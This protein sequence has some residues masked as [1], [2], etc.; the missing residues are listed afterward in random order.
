MAI[1]QLYGCLR[2]HWQ[3]H[4][5]TLA[6]SDTSISKIKSAIPCFASRANL[7]WYPQCVHAI[8][9]RA[10]LLYITLYPQFVLTI[11]CR[12]NLVY[13]A[14]YPQCVRTNPRL[15]DVVLH[16]CL[17]KMISLLAGVYS[18]ENMYFS[19]NICVAIYKLYG[20][21]RTHWQF[22]FHTLA[23]SDTSI[24]KLKSAIPRLSSQAHLARYPQC[25]V[26]IPRLASQAHLARYPQCVV[27]NPS[28]ANLLYLTLFPKFIL[29]IP[30]RASRAHLVSYVGFLFTCLPP[31]IKNKPQPS[32][33]TLTNVSDAVNAQ[34]FLLYL[35]LY[36]QFVR[37]NSRRAN[38][39][40]IAH[41]ARYTQFVYSPGNQRSQARLCHQRVYIY[42]PLCHWVSGTHTHESRA[43]VKVGQDWVH[44]CI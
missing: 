11:S 44:R 14:S 39:V 21:L 32:W 1:Y 16:K 40:Y 8:P 24:G 13:I 35:T 33:N 4:F 31:H 34:G 25:V 28:R 36:P 19:F 17:S 9:R 7:A 27:A 22:H 6:L 12:A 20:C 29:T 26:A 42:S 23:V 5:H 2:T 37:A 18:T 10:N 41:L 15:T 43:L 30:R 3:F 38:I